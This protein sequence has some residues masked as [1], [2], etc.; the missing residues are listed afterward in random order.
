MCIKGD[1]GRACKFFEKCHTLYNQLC[2][3]EEEIEARAHYGIA[4]AHLMFEK[5]S[6]SLQTT[7]PG[8]VEV[9]YPKW[10]PMSVSMANLLQAI[11]EWKENRHFSEQEEDQSNDLTT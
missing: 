9:S 1:F 10:L 6:N 7:D 8:H 11:V 5:F 4:S 2:L 3:K